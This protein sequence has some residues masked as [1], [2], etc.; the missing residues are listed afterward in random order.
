MLS[1][2]SMIVDYAYVAAR[3]HVSTAT[4]ETR[5]HYSTDPHNGRGGRQKAG[6]PAGT[7]SSPPASCTSY[8]RISFVGPNGERFKVL[9]HILVWLLVQ[10]QWPTLELDHKDGNGLNNHPDNLRLATQW[11]NKA[12]IGVKKNNKLGIKGV[13]FRPDLNKT[14]PYLSIFCAK[15]ADGT[16]PFQSKYHAT[17][18]AAS[19]WYFEK[20]VERFG[21]FARQ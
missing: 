18:G 3:F 2:V 16:R 12:N 11:Q 13:S 1:K 15:L 7:I 4:G 5:I 8:R 17:A 6:A 20:A 9:E 14:N 21:N 19:A 10:G